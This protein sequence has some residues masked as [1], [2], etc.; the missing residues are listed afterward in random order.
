MLYGVI[1]VLHLWH[2]LQYFEQ[3]GWE[4][5]WIVTA[6]DMIQTEF[7]RSYA[8]QPKSVEQDQDGTLR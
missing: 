4:P 3:A 7:N 8:A 5:E 6:K 1:V 2:K